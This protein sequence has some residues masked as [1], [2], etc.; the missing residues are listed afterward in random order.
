MTY[1]KG[2]GLTSTGE[3]DPDNLTAVGLGDVELE[4]KYRIVG[5]P[6]DMF[7]LGGGV[8][9]TAPTGNVTAKDKFI[10]DQTLTAGARV[11]ADFSMGPFFAGANLVGVYRGKGRVGTTEMG[12]EFRYGVAGGYEISPLLRVIAEG[13]GGTKFSAKNGTN[14]LERIAARSVQPIDSRLV[15]TIGGGAGSSRAWACRCCGR[16]ARRIMFVNEV[17]DK[18]GDGI[19]DDA[20]QVPDEPEDKDGFQDDDGCPD[21][22]NDGDGI[23][24][25]ARQVPERGRGQGRLPGRGRLPRSGQRRRRHPRRQGPVPERARDQERLRGRR[26]L[27]GRARQRRDGMPDAKDK[28]P[29]EPEDTDGFQDEDGCPDPDNDNDGIPDK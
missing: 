25:D 3:G 21:R 20:G 1:V 23:P 29:N 22:D 26:R 9:V 27:P 2:Q 24:D 4:G 19:P 6:T 11:I 10:G 12:P 18:D 28:C 15:F 5:S 8:F 14:S 7:V 16:F 17:G 13:F